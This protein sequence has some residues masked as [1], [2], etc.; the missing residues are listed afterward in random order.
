MLHN[1]GRLN[2][3]AVSTRR[4]TRRVG[5]DESGIRFFFQ[6]TEA[7]RAS[8]PLRG[9]I[10]HEPTVP[11][12]RPSVRLLLERLIRMPGTLSVDS[13][14]FFW[15]DPTAGLIIV[16]P[17]RVAFLSARVRMRA[18]ACRAGDLLPSWAILDVAGIVRLSSVSQE[19]HSRVGDG[20]QTMAGRGHLQKGPGEKTNS[21]WRDAEISRTRFGF[22]RLLINRPILQE[23]F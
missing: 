8:S 9:I 5:I 21:S 20:A 15:L 16:I 23:Y 2:N 13:F 22:V 4:G 6:H 3:V 17:S 18:C 12:V 10:P 11:S 19:H 1:L 14:F 7:S